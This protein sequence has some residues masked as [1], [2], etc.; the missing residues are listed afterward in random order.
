MDAIATMPFKDIGEHLR[1]L[2]GHLDT[3]TGSPEAK[4][5]MHSLDETLASLNKLMASANTELP[6]LIKSLNQTAD[7]ATR[8][9]DVLGGEG[10]RGTDLHGLMHELEEA[11]RSMRALSDFL[12]EHPEALL[13]GRNDEAK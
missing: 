2:L 1:D 6:P 11:A 13:K 10:G 12:Q 4:R 3:L 9:L 8:T 5:S 7:A